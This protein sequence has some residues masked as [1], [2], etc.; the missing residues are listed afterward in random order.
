M[1][2]RNCI[3]VWLIMQIK[4]LVLFDLVF[5]KQFMANITNWTN[6]HLKWS[7]DIAITEEKIYGYFGLEMAMLMLHFNVIANY[8]KEGIFMGLNNFKRTMPPTLFKHICSKICFC[9][10]KVVLPEDRHASPLWHS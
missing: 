7:F 3:F 8:W 1:F 2:Y 5:T 9:P 4:S 6:H 10:T